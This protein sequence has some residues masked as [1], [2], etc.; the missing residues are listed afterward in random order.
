MYELMFGGFVGRGATHEVAE[1]D[2]FRQIGS[3]AECRVEKHG[4]MLLLDDANNLP[5]LPE[6]FGLLSV[7]EMDTGGRSYPNSFYAVPLGGHCAL[8]RCRQECVAGK[9]A[10][11]MAFLDDNTYPLDY[12]LV[13]PK[14]SLKL[15]KGKWEQ[16]HQ[17][18]YKNGRIE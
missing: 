16:W 7:G 11:Q 6:G 9:V 14:G 12:Y 13:L 15:V 17:L 10:V 4:I 1:Q 3:E 18:S 5:E 8:P 2:L